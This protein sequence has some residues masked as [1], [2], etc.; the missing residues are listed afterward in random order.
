M[1]FQ[2]LQLIPEANIVLFTPIDLPNSY[3]SEL[4]CSFR[5]YT[6]KKNAKKT[7]ILSSY[8]SLHLDQL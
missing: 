6:L 5:Y 8:N 4:L 3:G 1:N 2:L 7:T